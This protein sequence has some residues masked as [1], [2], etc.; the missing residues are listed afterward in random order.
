MT[1]LARPVEQCPLEP[2]HTRNVEPSCKEKS[3]ASLRIS[4]AQPHHPLEAGNA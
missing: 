4:E 3:S 2:M 1:E